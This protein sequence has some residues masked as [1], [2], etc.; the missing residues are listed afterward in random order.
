MVFAIGEQAFISPE[1]ETVLWSTDRLGWGLFVTGTASIS[2]SYSVDQTLAAFFGAVVDAGA[3][4]HLSYAAATV[5]GNGIAFQIGAPVVLPGGTSTAA[6]HGTLELAAGTTLGSGSTLEFFGDHD[7]LV[8]W[9]RTLAIPISGFA[10]DGNQIVLGGA[11]AADV[12][13]LGFSGDT[14][15]LQVGGVTTSFGF[16]GLENTTIDNFALDR[17]GDGDPAIRYVP[18]FLFGTRLDTPAGPRPGEELSPGELVLTVENGAR[19]QRAVTWVGRGRIGPGSREGGADTVPVRVR[20]DAL[21]DGVPCRDLLL[22]PD[23]ALLLDGILV[24]VRMLVN[25]GSILR[26]EAMRNY[27]FF[28]VA[29]AR[30]G[31]LLAENLP[32]ESYL[33]DTRH[34]LPGVPPHPAP[35]LS[36]RAAP[37]AVEQEHV[38]PLWRRLRDRA[39][40]L[41]LLSERDAPRRSSPDPEP[42]LLLSGGGSLGPCRRIGTVVVFRIPPGGRVERLLSRHGVPA[43][44][45]GPF[46]DDRRRLGICLRHLRLRDGQTERV[47]Q[48]ASMV[49]GGWHDPEDDRRWTDG[50]A[51]LRLPP[52]GPRGAELEIEIVGTLPYP[53]PDDA[54]CTHGLP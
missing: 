37:L 53:L 23:H 38:E 35:S 7:S 40:T 33:P 43:E 17:D 14:L 24:P 39:A 54:A 1:G 31:I 11:G 28:H 5:L 52:A 10:G 20:R 41:G 18:C 36:A 15:Q 30:H 19:V 2:V 49:G 6:G 42:R 16:Q 44:T 32:A 45:I 27:C 4:A 48:A 13:L 29:L 3:Y 51:C 46:V 47:I 22:T 12:R 50:D 21:G 34:H 26:E 8:L 25:G 9:D